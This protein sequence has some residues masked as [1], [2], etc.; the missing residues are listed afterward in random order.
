MAGESPSGLT[1]ENIIKEHLGRKSLRGGSACKR[2][3]KHGVYMA[4][5]VYMA[6]YIRQGGHHV[7]HWPTFLVIVKLI[8][9]L[10]FPL[11]LLSDYCFW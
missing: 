7:G 3:V 4:Y 9:L 1:T 5:M 2:E 6:T 8:K 11:V 10:F